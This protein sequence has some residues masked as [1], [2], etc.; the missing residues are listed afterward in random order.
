MCKSLAILFVGLSFAVFLLDRMIKAAHV[1]VLCVSECSAFSV[2][3]GRLLL[4]IRNIN[5]PT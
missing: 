4:M 1:I 5:R 2:H 3:V